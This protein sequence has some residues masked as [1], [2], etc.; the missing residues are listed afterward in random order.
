MLFKERKIA[1]CRI[2]VRWWP[3]IDTYGFK[4]L[5]Q[6]HWGFLIYAFL[7]FEWVPSSLVKWKSY[8]SSPSL[9]II[10]YL[11]TVIKKME[12]TMFT[13][14]LWIHHFLLW[15]SA[16]SSHLSAYCDIHFP[17]QHLQTVTKA[18]THTHTHTHQLTTHTHTDKCIWHMTALPTIPDC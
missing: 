6:S 7:S 2:T 3:Q 14:D 10:S 15:V 5:L 12:E 11:F 1:Q 18:R 9:A 17:S 13:A 8:P 4:L 16:L